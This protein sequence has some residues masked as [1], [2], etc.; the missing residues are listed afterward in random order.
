MRTSL[1]PSL[2]F[3]LLTAVATAQTPAPAVKPA[4]PEPGIPTQ[5]DKTKYLN[6]PELLPPCEKRVAAAQGHPVD[7]IFIGDSITAGWLTKGAA[8]WAQYY[9]PRYAL[10]F[11]IGGDKTQNVLWRLEHMNIK[12]FR[13]KAGVIMIGT[14][15]QTNT[16]ADI[17]AGVKA[18]IVKTQETFPGIRLI[19]VSITPNRRA[20]AKMMAVDDVIRGYADGKKVVYLDLVPLMPPVGDNWKGLGPDHLHPDASGYKIWAEAMEPVLENFGG[21]PPPPAPTQE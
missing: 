6:R 15:N 14:N 21:L 3:A 20:N 4:I 1:F 19:L 7:V 2:G 16:V 10:D 11:G 13:P 18:V 17:A 5:A 8:T 9:A 12:G